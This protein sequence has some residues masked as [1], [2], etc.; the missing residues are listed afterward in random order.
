[1][2]KKNDKKLCWNCD[3]NVPLQ[4]DQ[5]PYCG[6]DL[7]VSAGIH[8]NFSFQE[9]AGGGDP[10]Y[11][12]RKE[13]VPPSPY[14]RFN[15]APVTDEEWNRALD[16]EEAKKIENAPVRE[17]PAKI[18]NEITALFLLLPGIVFFLFGLILFF[19]SEE[20]VLTLQWNQSFAYF[21]FLGALPLL[22]LG[23]RSLQ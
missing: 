9:D 21:Y 7:T 15:A 23:W 16:E 1:M 10:Y 6:V 19:F 13:V 8:S 22:V 4:M 20:G 3:G 2:G 5:C 14:S 17:S 18:K 11:V 12:E